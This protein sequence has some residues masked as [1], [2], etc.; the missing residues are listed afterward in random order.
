MQNTLARV[1][2][3]SSASKFSHSTDM[4]CHLHWLLFSTVYSL[5]YS[6]IGFQHSQQQRTIV[7]VVFTS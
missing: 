7:S 4:L 1:V 6:I 2:L 5:N 3:G